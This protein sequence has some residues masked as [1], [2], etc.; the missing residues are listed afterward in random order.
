MNK[1]DPL[2]LCIMG[3]SGIGKSNL[4]DLFTVPGWDP[5]RVRKP[6]DKD[7]KAMSK[8]DFETLLVKG[9]LDQTNVG[10]KKYER[11]KLVFP[12]TP[13]EENSDDG[14]FI[15]KI[16]MDKGLC[17]C[18]NWS[19]FKVRD[20]DQCIRHE[21]F[22]AKSSMRIEIFPPHLLTLRKE[23]KKLKPAIELTADNI[24]VVLLNPT[25]CSFENMPEPSHELRMSCALSVME[26]ARVKG[27]VPDLADALRRVG[28]LNEEL[29]A[30]KA[31]ISNVEINT[32]ECLEW[33]HFE[34]RYHFDKLA[35]LNRARMSLFNAIWK[36]SGWN[37]DEKTT[38][39]GR[40]Q[41]ACM[42]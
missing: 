39:A 19:F 36:R 21:D 28:Y 13:P 40:L 3:H 42:I 14:A 18:K 8:E 12:E 37:D 10:G 34:Y 25:A 11:G 35:E 9:V 27:E 38:W 6:R 23:W 2:Y 41:L 26:R 32:L 5:F 1:P 24:L 20:A 15:Q 22:K 4:S 33:S 7:D 31:F 17:I 16:Y 30:W 29:V